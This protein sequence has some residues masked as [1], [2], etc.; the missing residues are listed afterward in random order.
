[1]PTL[2]PEEIYRVALAAGFP[3]DKAEIF[4]AIALA[5]SRGNSEAN[6]AGSEDSRGLWQINVSPGVRE[7]K[8]GDL[9]DPLTN[10][11]AAYEISGG[12][13]KI[14]PWS[15][16]HERHAGTQQDYRSWADEAR[17]AAVAVGGAPLPAPAANGA[18]DVFVQSA[19]DQVGDPYVWATDASL[20]D[21]DPD[22]FDCSELVE[23]AAHRAGVRIS[24]GTW[25]QYLELQ[26]ADALTSVD[27]A[28]RTKGALLFHF[29]STPT[30]G[31][32]RPRQA[33]VAISLGDGR[34][35]EAAGSKV[36]ISAADP[37]RFN[38]AAV[39]PGLAAAVPPPT[40]APAPVPA[41]AP[42]DIPPTALY[43]AA[44]APL[45][46]PSDKEGDGLTDH[47][48]TLLGTALDDADSDD[49]GLG[50]LSEVTE[51]QTDPT[52]ADTD[53][54]GV[55]DGIEVADGSD[56]GRYRLPDDVVA[57]GFGGAAMADYDGDGASDLTEVG[58]GSSREDVDTDTD[59][60]A[61]GLEYA[62]GSDPTS[63]DSN[64]DGLTDG[65]ALDLGMLVPVL[66]PAPGPGTTDVPDPAGG[67]LEPV[68]VDAV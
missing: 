15:V 38:H 3:P 23:W 28:I 22:S 1:M 44:P 51:W 55:I 61:D 66:P 7:N 14:R 43:S 54:D 25:L 10:A 58:G 4:T 63:I 5:E 30:P 2:S 13:T 64:R 24:D 57:A 52:S 56:P 39:I 59:G 32:G 40:P 20:S 21:P 62:F 42:D 11:R 68:D 37:D 17:A 9:Y 60:I 48:E 35:V 27:E 53:G 12:G 45:P 33:H 8:W 47:F 19:L 50:D 16:T 31:G 6:A 67:A 65:V 34:I 46:P 18:V 29:S 26:E 41:P 36:Q 49:D